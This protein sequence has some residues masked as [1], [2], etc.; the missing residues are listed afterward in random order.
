MLNYNFVVIIC[1]LYA[2]VFFNTI[3]SCHLTY[4]HAHIEILLALPHSL[5]ISA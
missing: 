4:T 3:F 2:A 5:N 1:A